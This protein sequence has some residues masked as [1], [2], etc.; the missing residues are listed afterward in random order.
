MGGKPKA[1]L[2]KLHVLNAPKSQGKNVS[3]TSLPK[4]KFE[5]LEEKQGLSQLDY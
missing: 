1:V 5:D 3:G 4:V 2:Y